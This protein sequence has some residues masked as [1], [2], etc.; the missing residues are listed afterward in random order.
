[1][2]EGISMEGAAQTVWQ[3]EPALGTTACL[4]H[5][6]HI[7]GQLETSS[8]VPPPLC[9]CLSFLS[10]MESLGNG[11][12]PGIPWSS[13]PR[14]AQLLPPQA[15]HLCWDFILGCLELVSTSLSG[16]G[17]SVAAPAAATG[18]CQA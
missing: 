2:A 18:L 12:F 15:L 17:G 6:Q 4:C 8:V 5:C 14:P 16:V 13:S 9:P 11:A 7:W 10:S 3:R 1:M